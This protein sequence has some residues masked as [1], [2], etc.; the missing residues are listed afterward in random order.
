M[1]RI[2][3]GSRKG[4]RL[5]TPAHSARTFT[6]SGVSC[7]RASTHWFSAVA[8]ALPATLETTMR[9]GFTSPFST[10]PQASSGC[11][12]RQSQGFSG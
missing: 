8:I 2:I 6:N 10:L 9:S 7:Q 3:A 4:H 1:T 12:L 5:R 11:A